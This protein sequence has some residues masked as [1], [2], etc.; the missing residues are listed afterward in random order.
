MVFV[1]SR[2]GISHSPLEY[3]DPAAAAA[4][5]D[6]LTQALRQLAY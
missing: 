1:P 2:G 3:T 6:V 4:G 5:I